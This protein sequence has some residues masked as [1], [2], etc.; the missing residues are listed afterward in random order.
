MAHGNVNYYIRSCVQLM[1]AVDASSYSKRARTRYDQHRNEI[2]RKYK[3]NKKEKHENSNSQELLE[4]LEETLHGSWTSFA[5][6]SV[7]NTPAFA[8]FL[9]SFLSCLSLSLTAF[10][11][12]AQP[13]VP[14]LSSSAPSSPSLSSSIGSVTENTGPRP[15]RGHRPLTT[16]AYI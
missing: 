9:A 2:E 5:H 14:C 3:G 1:F 15:V 6:V 11:G 10:G 13:R 4:P 16:V 12:L 8:C 7:S